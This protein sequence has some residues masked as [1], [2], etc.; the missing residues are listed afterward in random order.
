MNLFH[1]VIAGAGVLLVV[2]ACSSNNSNS[3]PTQSGSASSA[4]ASG[5]NVAYI[6]GVQGD[7]FFATSVCGAQ[8]AAKAENIKLNVQVPA[9][10]SA[11]SEQ[12]I[13]TAVL[14]SKPKAMIVFPDDPVG[15]TAMLKQAQSQGIIVHTLS[16][17]ITDTTARSFNLH[18]DLGVGGKLAGQELAK[19][20]NNTG[21]VFVINVKPGISTTDARE[22]GFKSA[23]A[24]VPGMTYVGQQFGDND[25]TESAKRVTAELQSHPEIK[26]IYAT[27]IFAGLG[28]ITALK[29]LN[30]VGK[31]LLILHDTGPQEVEALQNGSAYGLIGTNA[32]QYGYQA[33]EA[34]KQAIEGG[35]PTVT[36][37][38]EKFVTKANLS[39]PEIQQQYIYKN[40]CS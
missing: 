24:T 12:P 38:P 5:A 26:G 25:P 1:R 32:Y 9:N 17:D 18:Q 31:V 36:L 4:S 33:V 40:S 8:A 39:N 35:T 28:A 7:A 15:I 14:A 30:L 16:A 2:A 11:Q 37:P 27:N 20:L 21:S 29:Q 34:M 6:P 23:I 3:A 22:A 13:L 10:F 19:A